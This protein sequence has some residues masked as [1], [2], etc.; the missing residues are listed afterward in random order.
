M[1]SPAEKELK[2]LAFVEGYD[3]LPWSDDS[4]GLYELGL[5]RDSDG[6]ILLGCVNHR[7]IIWVKVSWFGG[8]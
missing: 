2:E 6:T 4:F 1:T 7:F 5:V 3:K 8:A